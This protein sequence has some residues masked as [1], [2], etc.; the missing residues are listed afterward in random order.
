MKDAVFFGMKSM[1]FF[2]ENQNEVLHFT[3]DCFF[4]VLFVT[5]FLLIEISLFGP[6]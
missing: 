1:Q 3:I 4:S 6:R 2:Q 5:S